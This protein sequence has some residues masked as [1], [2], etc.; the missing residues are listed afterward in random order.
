MS[1]PKKLEYTTYSLDLSEYENNVSSI[2]NNFAS[3]GWTYVEG[4]VISYEKQSMKEFL[5]VFSRVKVDP[6]KDK[7]ILTDMMHYK[8]NRI[9]F[10]LTLLTIALNIAMFIIIY[11]TNTSDL[12][13]DPQLGID[14][15]INVI[16]MLL[17]F[18]AAEKTKSYSRSWG[19]ISIALGIV[20]AIRI[21]WIPLYY[22]L[23]HGINAGG[24]AACVVFLVLGA[25]ALIVSGVF[26]LFKCKILEEHEPLLKKE[27]A[28]KDVRT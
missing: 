2:L 19:S 26:T 28:K 8:P 22:F 16:F 7:V 20:Q 11:K 17:C 6:K 13:A 18:L 10:W 4:H 15:L 23:N 3:R 25:A 1:K 24:F 14:L 27:E 12:A 5:M 21:F 9:S